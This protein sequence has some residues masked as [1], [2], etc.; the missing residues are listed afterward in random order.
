MTAWAILF[1]LSFFRYRAHFLTKFNFVFDFK[2]HLF[3]TYTK[4]PVGTI[5]NGSA[6]LQMEKDINYI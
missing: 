2:Q 1:S 6:G 4:N 3:K 5:A